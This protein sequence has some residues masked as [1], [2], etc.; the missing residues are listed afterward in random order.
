MVDQKGKWI[1]GKLTEYA[2]TVEISLGCDSII[3]TEITDIVFK[4]NGNQ[5]HMW[6]EIIGKEFSCGFDT[7]YG[8]IE[9]KNEH[10]LKF[11]GRCEL[12][13][14]IDKPK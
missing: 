6:F 4:P 2:D 10:D 13:F 7:R 12:N 14:G 3:S 9:G 8:R 11:G 1:G 5:G